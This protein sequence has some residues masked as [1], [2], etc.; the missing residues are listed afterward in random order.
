MTIGSNAFRARRPSSSCGAVGPSRTANMVMSST[1][2]T[3]SIPCAA[4]RWRCSIWSIAINSSPAEPSPW[5]STPCSPVSVREPHVARWSAFWRSPTSA[6]ARRSSPSRCRLLSTTASFPI[7]LRWS[8]ASG[9]STP[10]CLSSSSGCPP[11]PS[12]IR[13]RQALEKQ[14]EGDRQDRRCPH[15]PAAWRVATARHQAD[16]GRPGDDS[17]QGR[18]A[19]RPLPDG[20]RRTGDGGA[21]PPSLR[22]ASRRSAIAAG[23][24]PRHVRLHRSAY[25]LEG[26]G[27][28]A[29]GRRRLARKGGQSFVL[30]AT[31]RREIP[32]RG[33]TRSGLDRK[34]L[35]RSVHPDHRPCAKAS[36]RT[37]R[38]RP[39]SRDRQTRQISS[40]D[41]RRSRLCHQGPSGDERAVR[42]DQRAIRAPIHAHHRQPA[43]RGMG[44]NLLRPSYDARGHRSYRA[45][46]HDPRNERRQLSAKGSRRQSTRSG[47]PADA[48]N[49]QG[50]SVIVAP[51]QSSPRRDRQMAILIVAAFPIQ[52][53]ARHDG[54]S[55]EG[56][57]L[58][59]CEVELTKHVGGNPSFVQKILITRAARAML[60][61]QLLDEKMADGSWSDHDARTFGGLSNS[62]RLTLRELGVKAAPVVERAPTLDQIE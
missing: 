35:A 33:G 50:I 9:Q 56:R 48:R 47:T 53:V 31:R 38:S 20:P 3:S 32:S 49:N 24:D 8:N 44:K 43:L 41:P 10:H 55:R 62:L 46:R 34:G 26:A 12:T 17:G 6:L 28:S 61:L 25:D 4:N 18:L 51:R 2:V 59:H 22:T 58:R 39:R 57:Y 11:S 15:R 19:R 5:R 27:A 30:R 54:R 36:D 16:L 29:R 52:I 60:R 42:A 1:I 37:P 45:P 13:S 23:K 7:S 14:H 40:A 21:K